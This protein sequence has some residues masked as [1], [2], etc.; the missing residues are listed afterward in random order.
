MGTVFAIGETV[1][2]IIFSKSVPVAAKPGGSMLNTSVSLGRSGIHV[3]LISE[4]GDDE[5]ARIISDFLTEN[6]VS[7]RY[8]QRYKNL[9][10]AIAL[11]FL[12]KN[13]NA[14]YSFYK[15]FPAERLTSDFPD[16]T[17]NDAVLF[18]SSYAITK[19]IRDKLKGF[20]SHTRQQGAL[21]LYDPNF[22]TPHL[23]ELEMVRP[24][25]LENISMSDIVRGSDEDFLNIFGV[26]NSTEAFGIINRLGKGVLIYTRNRMGVDF[27]SETMRMEVTVPELIPVSTI[28]A[29]DAFNGGI[30]Y[31]LISKKIVKKEVIKLSRMDWKDILG[32][33]IR[34]SSD[35]CLS[36]DN[37]ISKDLL[38][39]INS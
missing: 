21:I 15:Q 24:W 19:E 8:I 25:I 29:G 22:R 17:E 39:R 20:I 3:E 12:D 36:Y 13:N 32:W 27:V 30:L 33:G 14:H 35:V 6:G 9:K 7:T 26:K 23:N 5:T 28:G 34:F 1:F 38:N 11:A 4:T 37:Y 16:V 31:S 10:T 18:G 2:D